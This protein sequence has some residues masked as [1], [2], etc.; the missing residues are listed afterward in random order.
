[1]HPVLIGKT[2]ETIAKM[3]GKKVVTENPFQSAGEAW[4]NVK[5][6]SKK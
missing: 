5:P 4:M 6:K 3:T 1:M 2:P